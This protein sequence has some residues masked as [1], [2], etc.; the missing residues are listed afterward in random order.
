LTNKKP[1]K[2]RASAA[3]GASVAAGK[4]AVAD[5][6]SLEQRLR[7]GWL[8]FARGEQAIANFLLANMHDA[9][10]ETGAVIAA[11]AGV[12]EAS[13]A[14]FAR[15]LGYQDLK[16]MKR[17]LRQKPSNGE[18]D[19]AASRFRI[20]S[21]DH[22]RLARSLEMEHQALTAA[23]NLAHGK[24]WDRIVDHLTTA[25]RIN[26]VGFQ[27]VKG[28]ALDFSTRLKWVRG[29]V[30]FAEGLGGTYSEILLDDVGNSCVVLVDTAEY[31]AMTFRLCQ[32]IQRREIPLIV[33]TDKYS[34]WSR[35]FTDLSLEVSTRV[36]LYWDSMSAISSMLNLLTHAVAQRMSAKA[37]E[38]MDEL[39]E[40]AGSLRTFRKIPRRIG[41]R[42]PEE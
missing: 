1:K 14:R 27:A 25:T 37:A 19:N 36:D 29:G 10:F 35:E 8:D 28:L 42:M 20:G 3:K 17:G 15:K 41:N 24:I 40:L 5:E 18:L 13:V 34:H 9:A 38:R 26:C 2:A 7:D 33:V 12:S 30:R 4:P 6:T 21:E 39:E 16:D 23:Y 11:G 31:A 22:G 32:E